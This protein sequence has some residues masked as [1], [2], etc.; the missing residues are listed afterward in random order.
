MV[1]TSP[2]LL[3]KAYLEDV[4]L[5]LL[6]KRVPNSEAWNWTDFPISPTQ[7]CPEWASLNMSE[8]QNHQEGLLRQGLLGLRPRIFY[9]VGVRW[10]P[11]ICISNKFPCDAVSADPGATLSEWLLCRGQPAV[12]RPRMG[13]TGCQ[14]D[15]TSL[16]ESV[17]TAPKDIT[18]SRSC[19][20]WV[21]SLQVLPFCLI[22]KN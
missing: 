12:C 18:E 22:R 10:G 4:A 14:R 15:T 3:I 16:K 6:A 20:I 19:Y 13:P 5:R 2:L 21:L 11:R 17:L 8:H 9:W 1:T 7:N